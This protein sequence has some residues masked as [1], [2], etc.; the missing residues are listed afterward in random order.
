LNPE[1]LQRLLEKIAGRHAVV[2]VIGLGYVG[3]PV[4]LRFAEVGFPAIGLDIDAAKVKSVR[5]GQSYISHIAPARIAGALRQKTLRASTDMAEVAAADA[6]ILC[7]PTPLKGNNEPDMR[8][9]LDTADTIAPHLRPGQIVSLESTTY[10]GAT[11][12][13]LLPRLVRDGLNVGE[14]FFLVF[15][16]ER[17][18]PANPDYHTAVI[19][20]ICGGVTGRCLQAGT[21]LYGA[22]V[23]QVVPVSGTRAAELSKLLENT[24]RAVNIALVNEL[25]MLADKMDLDIFEIVRAAATKPFGFTAFHPGPG[26][27]GHCI[28]IDPFYLY[29]KARQ[30][31]FDARFIR[32]A[33]EIN[34]AMPAYVIAKIAAALEAAG[35]PLARARIL[36]LGIAYKKNIDDIRESPGLEIIARLRQAGAEVQY[37]DPHVPRTPPTRKHDLG[38]QSIAVN[39][40]TLAQYDCVAVVTDHDAFDWGLIEKESALI[41][42]SRGVFAPVAGKIVRA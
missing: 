41:V 16:P 34:T 17:E 7:L 27:G 23:E 13:D 38:L 21:A 39:S 12:E 36:V 29:W 32:L 25:K 2:A 30:Y 35:K 8:Y 4:C 31:G 20:K 1:P 11:E 26:L 37:S 15:S 9:V 14:N 5:R 19:P 10:P 28:P 40:A 24:Y 3:L 18:D 33:G 42:D 6:V 22:I